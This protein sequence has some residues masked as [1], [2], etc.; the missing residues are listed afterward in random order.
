[1]Q[2]RPRRQRIFGLLKNA[3]WQK[4]K[5]KRQEIDL[6]RAEYVL[7]ETICEH[8]ERRVETGGQIRQRQC[9]QEDRHC[10]ESRLVD[11]ETR[12]IR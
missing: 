5:D 8:L 1:M 10:S 7:G 12:W 3:W 6:R 11:V 4:P 9:V 2:Q